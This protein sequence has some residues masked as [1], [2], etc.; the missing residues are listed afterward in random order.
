MPVKLCVSVPI[1]YLQMRDILLKHLCIIMPNIPP[2]S[3]F[4]GWSGRLVAIFDTNPITAENN[5]NDLFDLDRPKCVCTTE[6]IMAC[7]LLTV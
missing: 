1:F 3:L 4:I 5:R 2:V 6:D 7:V